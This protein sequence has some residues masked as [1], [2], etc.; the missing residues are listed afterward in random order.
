MQFFTGL[1]DNFFAVK[2]QVLLM[3]PLPSINKVY[4]IGVQEETNNSTSSSVSIVEDRSILIDDSDTRKPKVMV[5]GPLVT[6]LTRLVH[7]F[8]PF[9]IEMTSQLNFPIKNMVILALIINILLQML[10]LLKI[11]QLLHLPATL[12]VS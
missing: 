8:A 12:M 7:G 9:A 1:D 11:V 4:S 10:L 2:T 6:L 3:G 5:K